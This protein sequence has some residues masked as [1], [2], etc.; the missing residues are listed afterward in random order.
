MKKAI[1]LAIAALSCCPWGVAA[2]D[3]NEELEASLGQEALAAAARGDLSGDLPG[4]LP[5]AGPVRLSLAESIGLALDTDESIQAAEAGRE[6]A[7]W[8]LS[9]AR[10]SKGPNIS[11]NAQVYRIGGRNYENAKEAHARYGNPHHVTRQTISGYVMGNEEWPVMAGQTSTVGSY[12]Y[13]NTFANSWSLSIPLYTGG[14]LE[15]QIAAGR[16]NLNRADLSLENERQQIRYRA[17]E[18][19]ANLLHRENMVRIAREAVDMADMQL[20][21]IGDQYSE[22][23]VAKADVLL[24]EVRRS[25][26]LQ[27]L[28]NAKGS[29]EVARKTLASVVGLPRDTEVEP[30][31]VFTYEPYPKDLEACE[32]AALK[33]RP[34]GL[35]A[36]YAVKAA[37]AQKE[38]AKAGYRPKITGVA[39]QNIASNAPFRSERSNSWEAGIN[40]SWSIFDNGVTRANVG[41][42][43]ATADQYRAE[44]RKVK[45]AICLETD[46]AYI[47]MKSAEQNIMGTAAAVKKAEESYMIAQVRYEEGVDILLSVADAQ[48][49]LTQARSNYCTALYQ[50]NL[51][52]AALEKAMGMPVGFDAAVYD[53]AAQLGASADKALEQA[54][55]FLQEEEEEEK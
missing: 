53:E 8:N 30:T 12:A 5:T 42:A 40:L 11:W 45:K 48:E 47:E 41:S 24:M 6:A 14:Q 4:D 32:E 15:G 9:A 25:N 43:A 10:R 54:E 1:V 49:R 33:N 20:K 23:A 2:A 27:N 52:R 29:A 37:E 3:D 18:A 34:D 16:Y 50:Y 31:D 46:S 35:A 39:N 22:G 21:L 28:V 36:E 19:Y 7:K 26:Y 55:K 51:Y 44:A 38:A 17:A 13:N